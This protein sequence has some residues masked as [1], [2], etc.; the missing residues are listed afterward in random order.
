MPQSKTLGKKSA[1]NQTV[2]IPGKFIDQVTWNLCGTDE[3]ELAS[4]SLIIVMRSLWLVIKIIV[5]QSRE[6]FIY[7]I[8][9][10]DF[11]V[12]GI[13]FHILQI[14]LIANRWTRW[15]CL[16]KWV[17]VSS[18]MRAS[19]RVCWYRLQPR[20]QKPPPGTITL[21]NRSYYTKTC[22]DPTTTPQRSTVQRPHNER[23]HLRKPIPSIS[24]PWARP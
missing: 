2:D 6:L 23:N 24:W 14:K 11:L 20:E 9:F 12:T 19:S 3:L 22:N 1:S 17:V 10:A 4:Y 18:K 13:L 7:K 16:W 5:I 15:R 8:F 21:S